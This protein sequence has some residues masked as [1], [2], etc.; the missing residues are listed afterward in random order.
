MRF[1]LYDLSVF[2]IL[3]ETNKHVKIV[4]LI[5]LFWYLECKEARTS[6]IKNVFI[7]HWGK[8]TIRR[9]NKMYVFDF[10]QA[11]F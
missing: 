7:V 8:K 2:L 10:N 1:I 4:F 5:F 11:Q 6:G 9:R 3:D